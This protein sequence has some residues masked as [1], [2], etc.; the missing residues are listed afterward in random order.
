[1]GETSKS[2]STNLWTSCRLLND[3]STRGVPHDLDCVVKS[4]LLKEVR[5]MRFNGCRTDRQ[6]LRDVFATAPFRYQLQDLPFSFG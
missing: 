4:E 3:S 2:V 6:H 1:M 5:A